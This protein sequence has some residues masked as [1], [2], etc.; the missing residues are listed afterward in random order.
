LP[1]SLPVG[2]RAQGVV[3]KIKLLWYSK[4]Y[5]D[6][7][8]YM[9]NGRMATW[10]KGLV[11]VVA[12]ALVGG[13]CVMFFGVDSS[14]I[15]AGRDVV[16]VEVQDAQQKKWGYVKRAVTVNYRNRENSLW[17]LHFDKEGFPSLKTG[18]MVKSSSAL[19]NRSGN[20]WITVDGRKYYALYAELKKVDNTNR[21]LYIIP[22]KFFGE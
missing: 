19:A 10:V 9:A 12:G 8:E 11:L 15:N 1:D 4:I 22:R 18:Q 2:I 14:K 20:G 5:G 3:G 21:F 13:F 17:T 16:V 7:E 6:K